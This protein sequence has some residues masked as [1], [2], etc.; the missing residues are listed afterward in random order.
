MNALTPAVVC[1]RT[2]F[3]TRPVGPIACS[4]EC[5]PEIGNILNSLFKNIYTFYALSI[6]V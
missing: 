6:R 5:G 3:Q 2:H 1:G 4:K